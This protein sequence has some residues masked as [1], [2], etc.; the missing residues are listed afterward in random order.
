MPFALKVTTRD[1]GTISAP[2]APLSADMHS[3]GTAEP[4]DP[5]HNTAEEWRTVAWVTQSAFPNAPSTGTSFLYGHACHYHI[6]SF[7]T[8][9]NAGIGNSITVTTPS[10][11]LRYRICATGVSP[12]SSNLDVPHCA[13]A[14]VDLVLV[15]CEYE[16]GDTSTNNFVVS[17]TLRSATRSTTG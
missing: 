13:N 17:A 7:T 9:S 16:I 1:D 5:P 4:I 12:K 14:P 3:D 10:D 8:L 6:C 11:V 15:T 2:I